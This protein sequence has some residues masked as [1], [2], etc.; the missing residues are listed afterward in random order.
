MNDGISGSK[1]AGS[2]AVVLG[3]S[4]TGLIATRV[5]SDHFERVTL[6]ER[7][8]LEDSLDTRKGVPQGRQPHALLQRGRKILEGL[9][10][11]LIQA[12][13]AGGSVPV[14]FGTEQAFH[15]FGYWKTAAEP[16][17]VTMIG[18][19]RPFLEQQ[20][21]KRVL[22]L[23]NLNAMDGC[24]L[25][26]FAAPADNS[27]ITGVRVQRPGAPE[28][29]L[30]ADLVVDTTGRGSRT[31]AWLEAMGRQKVKEST[32]KVDLGYA[33]RFFQRPE[34]TSHRWKIMYIVAKSTVSKR[35]GL[36]LPVEGG[37][38]LAVMVGFLGDHPPADHAGWME[39]A[40][41]LPAPDIYNAIQ[42]VQAI[43]DIATH[44]FPMD[45][46]RH[47][48]RMR[49]FP[50]GLAVLGDAHCSFNPV[51]AQ[52]ITTGAMGAMALGAQVAKARAAGHKALPPGFSREYQAVLAG[53][54]DEPWAMSTGED[55]RYPEA[56]GVR[57]FGTGLLHWYTGRI[58]QLTAV[59]S[60]LAGL[61]HQ[62][63][64]LEAPL[65]SLLTPAVAWK[66]LTT[67]PRGAGET[68]PS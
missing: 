47:Y 35:G 43:G 1:P 23:P 21:R 51:F 63:M 20:V 14:D 53:L 31:A 58:H 13:L 5:L 29:T 9:F 17:R 45:L 49:D 2:H 12:L 25:R 67:S 39:Y 48:E 55:M 3:G 6:V 57:P 64:H 54:C 60:Q 7:D 40:R 10:P 65:K 11:D 44:K 46:R 26:G 28:E 30:T 32:V 34:T 56:E 27:R 16:G 68:R 15:H 8:K 38:W 36:I 62:V 41:S 42:G 37:R 50:D 61:F 33:S 59:D 19:T 52:G 66:V 22:A 18:L 24:D 4:M